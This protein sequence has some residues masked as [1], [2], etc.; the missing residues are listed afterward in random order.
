M[1]CTTTTKWVAKAI[2]G[3][4]KR[5]EESFL[6]VGG[7]D[8]RYKKA[9]NSIKHFVQILCDNCWCKNWKWTKKIF[10][11]VD[12]VTENLGKGTAA[13][14]SM[15]T[16]ETYVQTGKKPKFKCFSNTSQVILSFVYTGS[17]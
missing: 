14:V 13:S 17:Q 3:R 4:L 5:G 12:W 2:Q 7:I 9:K 15:P 6:W 11:E 1:G 16:N 8:E 10:C